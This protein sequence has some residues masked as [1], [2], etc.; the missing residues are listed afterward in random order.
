MTTIALVG[1]TPAITKIR[2]RLAESPLPFQVVDDTA[3]ADLIVTDEP[4]P[5]PNHLG[6][7]SADVPDH[8]FCSDESVDYVVAALTEAHLAG[9]H[10]VR[11]RRTVQTNSDLPVLGLHLPWH[12]LAR[13]LSRRTNKFDAVDYDW[14][15][16]ESIDVEA[17]DGEVVVQVADEELTARIRARGAVDANDGRFH[18]VG[19]LYSDRA[20][21]LKA[22][23][24]SSAT[25]AL[26]GGEAVKAKLAEVTQWGTVR[27]TGVGTPPWESLVVA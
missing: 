2:K 5:T 1:T 18:W 16:D 11:V 6:V 27:M 12:R 13:K 14:T 3:L 19:M 9:A 17:F 10:G 15:T 21:E 25:V 22:D 26:P 20:A 8:F 4:A 7:A 24:K 23:G